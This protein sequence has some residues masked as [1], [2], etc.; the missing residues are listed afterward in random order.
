MAILPLDR[1]LQPTGRSILVAAERHCGELNPF[2]SVPPRYL[3]IPRLLVARYFQPLPPIAAFFL[4]PAATTA[5]ARF[6]CLSQPSIVA[7]VRHAHALGTDDSTTFMVDDC[8]TQRN[9]DV[10]GRQVTGTRDRGG[11]SR[12]RRDRRPSP[13]QPANGAAAE[14]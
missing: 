4:P 7:I 6:A 3:R 1:V 14:N 10:R 2:P 8:T 12:C 11:D 13:H 5:D 9:L